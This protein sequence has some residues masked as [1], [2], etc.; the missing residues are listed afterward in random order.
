MAEE[1][2]V[3]CGLLRRAANFNGRI[4]RILSPLVGSLNSLNSYISHPEESAWHRIR[5]AISP[6]V[7]P[8]GIQVKSEVRL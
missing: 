7:Q 6:S 3:P 5:P 1:N 2:G 8:P 4:R